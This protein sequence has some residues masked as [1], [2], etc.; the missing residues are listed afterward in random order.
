MGFSFP[1]GKFIDE[2]A[3]AYDGKR[4]R[5]PIYVD[6]EKCSFSGTEAAT[7]RCIEAG[8]GKAM[9]AE[10]VMSSI[11]RTLCALINKATLKTGCFDCLVGGGVAS[12]KYLRATLQSELSQANPSA[13]VFFSDPALSSDNACG[14]ALIA[15]QLHTY[16][17]K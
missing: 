4:I 14:V 11:T 10:G 16:S 17:N 13:K 3:I 12:S 1:S 8:E 5:L 15:K 6:N 9:I 7:M 2:L